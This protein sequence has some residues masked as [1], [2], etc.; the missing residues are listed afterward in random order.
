MKHNV[1]INSY[2]R[3]VSS[4]IHLEDTQDYSTIRCALDEYKN[5]L[6]QIN[7]H[8]SDDPNHKEM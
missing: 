3:F 6:E 4:T 7:I 8:I 1:K 5:K 2:N